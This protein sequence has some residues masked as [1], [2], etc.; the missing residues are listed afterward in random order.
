MNVDIPEIN[1]HIAITF[2]Q[3]RF[4]PY[5]TKAKLQEMGLWEDLQQTVYLSAV[6]AQSLDPD[7]ETKE[8]SRIAAREIY[9]FLKNSGFKREGAGY[10]LKEYPDEEKLL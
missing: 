9:Q 6:E 2:S 3:L 10:S 4:I 8:I 1:R 5:Y 7:M